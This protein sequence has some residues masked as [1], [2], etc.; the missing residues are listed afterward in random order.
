MARPTEP[1]PPITSM[2]P[3]SARIARTISRRRKGK[4]SLVSLMVGLPKGLAADDA[5]ADQYGDGDAAFEGEPRR[6]L[7]GLADARRLVDGIDQ[8]PRQAQRLAAVLP[9]RHLPRVEL[10][11]LAAHGHDRE[12]REAA[13]A[14]ERQHVDAVADAAALH[15]QDAA[16]SAEP[17]AGQQ[18][19]ALLLGGE[20]DRPDC[21]LGTAKIDEPGMPGIGDI[22]DL[23]DAGLFEDAKD[24]IGPVYR[25]GHSAISPATL[26]GVEQSVAAGRWQA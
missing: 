25:F 13:L 12:Q 23:T 22:G 9:H 26:I 7:H 18:R 8:G 5:L 1:S 17:G 14:D 21:I 6:L 10:A 11:P 19:H 15:E 24:V 4:F 16:L 20:P 3:R 2:S